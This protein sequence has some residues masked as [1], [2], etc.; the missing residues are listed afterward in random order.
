MFVSENVALYS[1]G[2]NVHFNEAVQ[3]KTQ[4]SYAHFFDLAHTGHD[5]A[6]QDGRIADAR[7]VV[8]F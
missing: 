6:G 8:A 3:L 2:L 5:H 4:F 1:A 7:L